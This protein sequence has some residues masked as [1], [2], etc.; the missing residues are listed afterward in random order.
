MS[1]ALVT[2][3]RRGASRVMRQLEPL[4]GDAAE[5]DAAAL[6]AE[7]GDLFA[8]LSE[9]SG[10]V[11]AA[12]RLVE[13]TLSAG[14]TVLFFGNGGSAAQ[15]QHLA[16]ELVGR[17]VLDRRPYPAVAL[18]ADPAVLTALANDF[19]FEEAFARQVQALARP[20]DLAVA[21]S[22]SGR[23]ANVVGGVRMAR[24]L[25]LSTV[26]LTGMAGSP[27]AECVD[28][29]V[30]VE[31]SSTALVQEAHLA[32]GHVIC[33][34]VEAWLCGTRA[35]RDKGAVSAG[36]SVQATSTSKRVDIR[37]LGP[38][39][40][41][42]RAAGRTVVWT[43]GCFDL[44]HAGH[45]DFLERAKDLGDVLVVGLN[46]DRTVAQLKGPDRPVV[47]FEDRLSV[48]CA[49]SCVDHVVELDDLT[50]AALLA[51]LGPD[52]HC[53]G[54]DYDPDT[55]PEAEAVRSSGGEVRTLPLLG[56]RSTTA[57]LARIRDE[58]WGAPT[59]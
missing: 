27:V 49:L 48:L 52:V 33:Q 15:A 13:R 4:A 22:T 3:N 35:V 23:S 9:L 10:P 7:R 58:P 37:E 24:E 19:G 21:L 28:V 31:A 42:W 41:R 51:K 29:V 8:S 40:E 30:A 34:L 54:D 57:L 38:L 18:G 11:A 55:I 39:R 20:G 50:P 2:P 17:F 25:G 14:G 32:V 46:T 16:A 36:T 44:L 12:A 43:N 59:S 6:L 1:L 56:G 53:K 47:S 5:R 26:A 45:V